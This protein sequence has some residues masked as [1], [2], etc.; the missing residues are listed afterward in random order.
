L[1][2]LPPR[3]SD[4]PNYPI[5]AMVLA[6]VGLYVLVS[7]SVSERTALSRHVSRRAHGAAIDVG[8]IQT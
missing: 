1:R 7:F 4:Y 3:L 2:D 8:R 5:V 6:S